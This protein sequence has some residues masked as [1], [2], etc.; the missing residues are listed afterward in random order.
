MNDQLK[1]DIVPCFIK[2]KSGDLYT[3]YY[4]PKSTK[5]TPRHIIYIPPFSE[6]A[7]R[8]RA[9]TSLQ[10]RTLAEKGIGVFV[11]DLFGTGDSAGNFVEGNWQLWQD[12][13]I[14]GLN[15]LKNKYGYDCDTLWGT[16]LGAMLAVDVALQLNSIKNLIFWQPVINGKNFFTQFLRIRI[17]AELGENTGTTSTT[18]LRQQFE[19]GKSVEISGYEVSPDLAISIDKLKP[20]KL[21]SL[22]DVNINWFEIHSTAEIITPRTTQKALNECNKAGIS[23][24]LHQVNGPAFWQLHERFLAPNLIEAT[25]DV[26]TGI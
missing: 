9:M 3:V 2:G 21:L 19:A 6:E 15:W 7:N 23:I 13:I 11:I 25:T 10:A 1:A 18:E 5:Q 16:R 4:P 20:S 22:N 14:T 24:T 8:C 17:A 26:I 12:N